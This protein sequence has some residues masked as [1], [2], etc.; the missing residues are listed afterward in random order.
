MTAFSI[1]LTHERMPETDSLPDIV[2]DNFNYLA[3]GLDASEVLMLVN[4]GAAG[5][6]ILA[7]TSRMIILRRV[8]FLLG[9]GCIKFL[10][11][12]SWRGQFI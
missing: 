12:P 5:I 1:V 8:F 6:L 3:W 11:P 10:N 7:H 9:E 4:M 2:L